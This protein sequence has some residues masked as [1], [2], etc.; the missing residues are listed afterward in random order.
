M[1]PT[2]RFLS[3]S[4]SRE[5]YRRRSITPPRRRL[6]ELRE[7]RQKTER[8]RRQVEDLR[9]MMRAE[10]GGG[11]GVI[12]RL[13]KSSPASKKERGYKLIVKN[14]PSSMSESEFYS[15]FIRKGELV[16]C[17]KKNNVGFVVFKTREGANNAVASLN[18]TKNGNL[19]L[20]VRE[21]P[22]EREPSR[23]RYQD[24]PVI[25]PP[26]PTGI[27]SR[28]GGER[29]QSNRP[30][31]LVAQEDNERFQSTRSRD[32]NA[33]YDSFTEFGRTERMMDRPQMERFHSE[34]PPIYEDAYMRPDRPQRVLDQ[35]D[36]RFHLANSRDQGYRHYDS[37][38]A[39]N[40]PQRM[41]DLEDERFHEEMM[42]EEIQMSGG[43][44]QYGRMSGQPGYNMTG[45][46]AVNQM[47]NMGG[48]MTGTIRGRM[49]DIMGENFGENYGGH[50]SGR[51][52]EEMAFRQSDMRD[53]M[54]PYRGVGIGDDLGYN[55][56]GNRYFTQPNYAS[57]MNMMMGGDE[58]DY[59]QGFMMRSNM[60]MSG[61]DR[62]LRSTTD[63]GHFVI[64]GQPSSNVN[65]MME[66]D[67]EEE[68]RSSFSMRNNTRMSGVDRD[69]RPS[70]SL[71]ERESDS[72]HFVIGGA[73]S[74]S[75]G[76]QRGRTGTSWSGGGGGG[77]GRHSTWST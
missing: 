28:L 32:C 44:K 52:E 54:G 26:P 75:R 14:F 62:D 64:G 61:V 13:G 1:L 31:R 56:G 21:V 57:N 16:S 22:E 43:G 53:E 42:Q 63:S 11:G 15:M 33:R 60:K 5:K 24:Q 47:G 45:G 58:D 41:M 36:E 77:G 29:S 3:R 18:G 59:R 23:E 17:Q 67:E 40:R 48:M 38:P 51:L 69:L 34:R 7:E 6:T 39:S 71:R 68:F 37:F 25:A 27:F 50:S 12:R 8:V 10:G 46:A 20:S 73:P 35:H 65:M 19:T 74:S 30:R 49:G 76:T 4:R 9:D 66:E 70:A 72:G 55:R 2:G